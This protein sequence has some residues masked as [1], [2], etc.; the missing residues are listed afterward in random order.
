ME[1]NKV[2]SRIYYLTDSE[3]DKVYNFII[4]TISNYQKRAQILDKQLVTEL[5]SVRQDKRWECPKCQQIMDLAP[6]FCPNCGNDVKN[7]EQLKLRIET[8]LNLLNGIEKPPQIIE[9]IKQVLTSTKIVR[10]E[11]PFIRKVKQ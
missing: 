6:N 8:A 1:L 7:K 2:L 11:N 9:T 4:D 3:D 5:E 10:I